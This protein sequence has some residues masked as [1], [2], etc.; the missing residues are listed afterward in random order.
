[1]STNE[2]GDFQFGSSLILRNDCEKM[3]GVETDYKRNFDE[4]VKT[5]CS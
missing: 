5:L 4:D 1:M 2:S 3:L